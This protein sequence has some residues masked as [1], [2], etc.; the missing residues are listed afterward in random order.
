MPRKLQGSY[1]YTIQGLIHV[2]N[3]DGGPGEAPKTLQAGL[4]TTDKLRSWTNPH[5]LN[6]LT[7]LSEPIPPD[8]PQPGIV[9]SLFGYYASRHHHDLV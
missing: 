1:S 3:P 4:A 8:F 7:V 6:A 9:S 5:P 2:R